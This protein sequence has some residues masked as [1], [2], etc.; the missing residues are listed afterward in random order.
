MSYVDLRSDTL[1]NPCAV[2]KKANLLATYGDDVYNEDT[3]TKELE[4]QIAQFLCLESFL[5]FHFSLK[6]EYHE[7]SI[8]HYQ[9][10]LLLLIGFQTTYSKNN[11][12]SFFM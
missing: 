12:S 5:L 8:F 3:I 7:Q 4:K 10:F 9:R 2:M 1:T 6:L 11:S